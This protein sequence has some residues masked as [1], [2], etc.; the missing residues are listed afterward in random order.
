[1]RF[2]LGNPI[3]GN[4]PGRAHLFHQIVVPLAFNLEMRHRAE[5][6]RFDKIVT[7]IGVNAR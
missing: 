7:E 5:L 6:H 4:R 3:R 2:C 1:M